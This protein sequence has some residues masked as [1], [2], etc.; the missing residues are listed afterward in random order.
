M[1]TILVSDTNL[2]NI[3]NAIREKNGKTTS[4]KVNEMASAIE[5]I[6]TSGGA[7]LETCEVTIN[8][9]EYNGVLGIG[10][11]TVENGVVSTSYSGRMTSSST[12]IS[13]VLCGSPISILYQILYSTDISTENTTYI[14]ELGT[15]MLKYTL[16]SVHLFKAPTTS[17]AGVITITDID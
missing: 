10:Y 14:T 9:N 5:N 11:T 16:T 2:T 1:A 13:N 15:E 3:A 6:S 4:Y 7:T 12:T 8:A 17:Q